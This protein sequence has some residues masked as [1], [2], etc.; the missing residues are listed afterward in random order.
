MLSGVKPAVF[1]FSR[2]M[3]ASIRLLSSQYLSR[4]GRGGDEKKE[5]EEEEKKKVTTLN[6][7][8]YILY[9]FYIHA[10]LH[11]IYMLFTN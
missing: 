5:E 4:G 10:I 6:Y 7:A 2:T 8:V 1:M 11:A 9:T 3:P